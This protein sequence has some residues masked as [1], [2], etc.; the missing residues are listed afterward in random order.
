MRL[1]RCRSTSD[2]IRKAKL[3]HGEYYSYSKVEYVNQGTHVV[4]SCPLHGEFT[5]APK[6]HLVGRGCRRCN[7]RKGV[8]VFIN[9]ASTKHNNKYDYSLVEMSTTADK[10]KIICPVH[11]IFSQKVSHHLAGSGCNSCAIEHNSNKLRSNG[12]EFIVKAKIIH[13]DYYDYSNIKYVKSQQ[14]VEIICKKHGS[15]NITPSNHLNGKGCTSCT[16]WGYDNKKSATLYVITCENLIKVGITN[17]DVKLRLNSISKS[18]GQSFTLLNEFK[19]KGSD[20]RDL[21]TKVL[22]FL[23]KTYEVADCKF[24]GWTETFKNVDRYLLLDFILD[25]YLGANKT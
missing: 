8:F 18:Y 23:K 7:S 22:K 10:V 9:E 12:E 4:I 15:F 3:K 25:E 16:S 5:Q 14:K 2:F 24:D 19:G 20:I 17:R 6:N 13:G 21:E 1:K 11:G